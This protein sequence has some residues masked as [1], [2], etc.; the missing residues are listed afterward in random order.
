MLPPNTKCSLSS[1]FFPYD[2]KTKFPLLKSKRTYKPLHN[3]P[4]W[5]PHKNVVLW[6]IMT[7][8]PTDIFGYS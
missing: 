6:G 1:Q 2:I 7:L 3:G 5:G 4:L 8:D